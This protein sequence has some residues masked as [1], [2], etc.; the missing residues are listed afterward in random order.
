MLVGDF[1]IMACMQDS[2]VDLGHAPAPSYLAAYHKQS[3]KLK[4]LTPRMTEAKAEECDSHHARVVRIA[5]RTRLVLMGGNQ[6]DAYD[7]ATG[8]LVW[9]L[10]GVR[11][12]RTITGPTIA[13]DSVFTRKDARPAAGRAA[14]GSCRQRL[15]R[16]DREAGHRGSM[17]GT[18]D[19]CCPVVWDRLVFTV[20]DNGVARCFDAVNGKLNGCALKGDYKASPLAAEGQVYF[21]NQEGFA[22]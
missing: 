10:P 7:P 12:G 5:A 9:R 21:V 11:D 8:K 22:R 17:S 18:P 13:G 4:W 1:V 14:A 6:L 20:A 19:A 16:Q 15:G 2:L 3:G